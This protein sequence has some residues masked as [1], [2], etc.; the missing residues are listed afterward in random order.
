MIGVRYVT[1][2]RGKRIAVQLDLAVHGEL[3][4]DLQDV[5]VSRQRETEESI[6]LEEVMARL[7]KSGKLREKYTVSLK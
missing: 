6:P 3:W 4:E 7:I 2:E 1:D 5:L